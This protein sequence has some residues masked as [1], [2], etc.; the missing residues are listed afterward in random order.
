VRGEAQA[1]LACLRTRQKTTIHSRF[2]VAKESGAM[3]PLSFFMR[4][5]AGSVPGWGVQ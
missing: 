3:A 4:A 1:G 5:A 2:V